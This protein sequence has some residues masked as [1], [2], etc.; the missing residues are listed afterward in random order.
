MVKFS[1][2]LGTIEVP[3][4]HMWKDRTTSI[5]FQREPL[6]TRSTRIATIGSC[7]AAEIAKAMSRLGLRG[8]MHPGG[9]FYTSRSIRQEMM[10]IFSNDS[11]MRDEPLWKV[12]SGYVHPF[13]NIYRFL[14]TP[15]GETT[16]ERVILIFQ[17][18]RSRFRQ[19]LSCC[20]CQ[21]RK[22]FCQRC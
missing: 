10:R 13:Q 15:D 6:I 2:K 7:F 4:R 21:S 16:R 12:R 3:H 11:R 17:T 22:P 1:S 9:L 18:D 19:E 20:R 8:A 5:C 14:Q